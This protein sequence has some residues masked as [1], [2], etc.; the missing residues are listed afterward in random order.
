MRLGFGALH[1]LDAAV[2]P[3]QPGSDCRIATICP[4]P[5]VGLQHRV[6]SYSI[7]H[8]DGAKDIE[9][10]QLALAPADGVWL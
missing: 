4:E 3:E 7:G 10:A 6:P 1:V 8:R 2:F 9:K 5:A